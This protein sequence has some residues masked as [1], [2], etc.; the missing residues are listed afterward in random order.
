MPKR[1]KNLKVIQ[2]DFQCE[3]FDYSTFPDITFYPP[4]TFDVNITQT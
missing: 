3:V 4:G 1:F 2:I